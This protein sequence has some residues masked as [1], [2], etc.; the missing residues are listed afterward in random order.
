[1][2]NQL[3]D[4]GAVIGYK[5]TLEYNKKSNNNDTSEKEEQSSSSNTDYSGNTTYSQT[6]TN[7]IYLKIIYLVQH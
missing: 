1:M 5:P 7:F 3:E 2:I 4:D 6:L